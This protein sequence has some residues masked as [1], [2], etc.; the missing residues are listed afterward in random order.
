MQDPYLQI[1]EPEGR[2]DI[3]KRIYSEKRSINAPQKLKD[4]YL[5]CDLVYR[6]RDNPFHGDLERY[7]K[8]FKL[9]QVG[10]LKTEDAKIRDDGEGGWEEGGE[11]MTLQRWRMRLA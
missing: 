5:L 2:S 6:T 9:G 10:I 8:Y 7:V 1:T 3:A 11:G 4:L